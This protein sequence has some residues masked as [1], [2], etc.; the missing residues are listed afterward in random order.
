MK[1]SYNWLKLYLD[2]DLPPDKVSEL[3]TGCG[4][5]VENIDVFQTVKGG[6][7][8]VVIGEVLTCTKHPGADHLSLTTVDIGTKTPLS[9]VCGAPNVAA[10][11]KVPVATIGTTLYLED[12]PLTLKLSKI[13]G[14]VSE[15]MICAED[16]LGLGTSHAGIV[17]LP[18]EIPV[19]TPAARYFNIETDTI[20]TIGLTPN[21]TDA[22]SHLGVARDLLAVI[23][24]SGHDHFTPSERLSL[25]IPDVAS[26]KTDNNQRHIDVIVENQ[27]GCPRY[28]GIT[29]TGITVK[30]SPAWLKNKLTAIGLRPINN[31]VDVTNF[32]LMEL[33]QPLHAFDCDKI[34]GNKVI[35]KNYPAGTTFITLDNVERTLTGEDMMICNAVEP[36]V[37]AGVLGGAKSGIAPETTSVFLESACFD[38]IHVRKSARHHGLQTDA[39]FRFERG[40]DY[41]ITEFALKRA[42]LMILELAGGTVSSEIVDVCPKPYASRNVVLSFQHLDR[43]I[44]KM[45]NRDV[46]KNILHDLGIMVSEEIGNGAGLRLTIPG[47]KADVTNE[48]D[49]IE[50]ILRIYGYNNIESPVAL[51]S[52]ISFRKKTDPEK[53][54]NRISEYLSASGFHEIINNSLTKSVYYSNNPDFYPHV[55]VKILNPISRDLDVLRQSLLHGALES[56]VLNQ[57][58]KQVNLKFF[59]F[60]TVYSLSSEGIV[61]G[62]VET[63]HLSLAITG[64]KE[65]ENWNNT[66]ND[67][68]FF[69]LK[70]Y[71]EAIFRLVNINVHLFTVEPFQSAVFSDGLRYSF[72]NRELLT[73]GLLH[74]SLLKS[75]DYKSPVFYAELNWDH[76]LQIIPDAE[77]KY[78][79]LSKFPEVRRDLAL[80]LDTSVSFHQ[81]EKLAYKTEKKLLRH[82][83]LFDV[84]EGEKIEP[85]KQSYALSF[86][87]QDED[88]TLTDKEI[89]K[90]MERMIKAFQ[91]TYNARIR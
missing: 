39:S 78:R 82:V 4:L 3:L 36:M 75:M 9:I 70:G 14:E 7:Q 68:D 47:F 5:E 49:V 79:E 18:P 91:T 35:V 81:I 28:T 66:G 55:S 59:E 42:S 90:V 8:G 65:A 38:P 20:F 71:V 46:V 67:T 11:Q 25:K 86:I 10:G 43:L 62:Y 84:Y 6:L 24:N 15:G 30:E 51:R 45:L 1:I 60:G 77:T 63:R 72:N 2:L 19:G 52:S 23:N 40:T 22:T 56:L 21:R 29:L 53:I 74:A 13:R 73:L 58:R 88:K 16:E 54:Q 57:N 85:G 61:P 76:L 27:T 80:L 69:I 48:A 17:V 41:N 50:E 64:K 26:F 34:T 83:G 87:L 89:D 31:V 32:I 33:G 44:G 37:I 12:K